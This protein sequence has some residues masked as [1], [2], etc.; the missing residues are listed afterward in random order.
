MKKKIKISLSE[1][2][3][4]GKENKY[5]TK[6]IKSSWISSSGKFIDNFEK[7]ISKKLKI[8]YAV[9]LINCTQRYN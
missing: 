1:P 4:F 8:K 5:L 2:H 9:A 6:C 3:F 7:N